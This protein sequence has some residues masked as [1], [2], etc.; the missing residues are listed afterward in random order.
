MSVSL[1][2]GASSGI[3][4][5]I[6]ETLASVGHQVIAVDINPAD[7]LIE[8][9]HYIRTDLSTEAGIE[10]L[11]LALSS[12]G[13]NEINNLIHCAAVGQWSSLAETARTD[14]ERIIRINLFGTIGITQAV[15]PLIA[16]RGSVVLFASGTV[17][18]GP[19]K[20]FAYVASKGGVIAFARSLSEE[21]GEREITVNVICPGIT[22]TPMIRPMAHTEEA[23]VATRS[24]K[25]RAVPEDIVGSVLFLISKHSRFVTGQTLCVDGGSVKH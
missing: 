5:K 14:W 25:R 8:G 13:I 3:G 2:T 17:F 15:A 20:L 16:N 7:S 21:L 1:V 10:Q 6:A 19:K 9:V 24:I 4:L 22:D 23:N 11:M 12:Q 18:K